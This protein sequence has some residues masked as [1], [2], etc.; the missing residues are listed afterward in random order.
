M[1]VGEYTLNRCHEYFHIS[2][3]APKTSVAACQ[4][5]TWRNARFGMRKMGATLHFF[6]SNAF[7]RVDEYLLYDFSRRN[8][9]PAKMG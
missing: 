1:Q 5:H 9:C 6:S 2:S 8:V 4:P 3:R 7:L